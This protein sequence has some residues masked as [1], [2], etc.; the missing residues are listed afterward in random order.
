MTEKKFDFG[1]V[2]RQTISFSQIEDT[3]KRYF[4]KNQ[5]IIGGITAYSFRWF[6]R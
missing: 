2:K 3:F 1:A 5:D 6:F 4:Q